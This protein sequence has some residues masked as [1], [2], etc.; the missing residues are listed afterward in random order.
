M[1]INRNQYSQY[2]QG[3]QKVRGSQDVNRQLS[4]DKAVSSNDAKVNQHRDEVK[5]TDEAIKISNKSQV[6]PS[7]AGVR[8]DLVNRVKSE[9]AAGTYDTP[10][11]MD[12][13]INRMVDKLNLI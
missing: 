7:T 1:E 5:F 13:A 11:K 8:F 10:D 2:S 3:I 6:E 9:I 4:S 12:I